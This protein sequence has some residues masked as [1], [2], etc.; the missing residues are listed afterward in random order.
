MIGAVYLV[1]SLAVSRGPIYKIGKTTMDRRKIMAREI[2]RSKDRSLELMIGVAHALNPYRLERRIRARF[3]PLRYTYRGSG[4]TEYL[5]PKSRP[6]DGAKIV[7]WTWGVFLAQ[8]AVFLAAIACLT[9]G[10]FVLA[11]ALFQ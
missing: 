8:W 7:L 10:L 11:L 6:L 3:R 2:N 9:V 5:R 1:V 4:K